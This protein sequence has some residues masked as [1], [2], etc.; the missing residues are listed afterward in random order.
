MVMEVGDGFRSSRVERDRVEEEESI[1]ST[2]GV[3]ERAYPAPQWG[4]ET[5]G[6]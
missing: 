2:L 6:C 3:R 1:D 4:K 5:P